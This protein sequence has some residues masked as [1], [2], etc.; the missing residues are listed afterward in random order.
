MLAVV[1][2]VV[3]IVMAGADALTRR[4]CPL[5]SLV[6]ATC[7]VLW[8]SIESAACVWQLHPTCSTEMDVVTVSHAF[9]AC[10]PRLPGFS[11]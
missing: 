10:Y 6:H 1:A 11:N 7:F 8:H 4:P 5:A 9:A 3:V 2:V